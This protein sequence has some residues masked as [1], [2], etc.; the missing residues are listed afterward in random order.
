MT[1][2]HP[3]HHESKPSQEARHSTEASDTAP[4]TPEVHQNHQE[5]KSAGDVETIKHKVEQEAKSIHEAKPKEEERRPEHSPVVSK[6]HKNHAYNH[7]L[8]QIRSRLSL[9]EKVLSHVVHQPIVDKVSEVGSKTVARPV[10]LLSAGFVALLGS[11][12]TLFLA[13]KYGF[14]YNLTLF[15]ALFLAGYLLGLIFEAI[16]YITKTKRR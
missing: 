4:R 2:K 12:L 5:V 16:R 1:E 10:S 6:E 8:E 14:R 11:S 3:L 15:F 13:R 9:P 7:N